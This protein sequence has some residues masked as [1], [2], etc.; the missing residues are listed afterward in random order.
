M[1]RYG[2]AHVL[3]ARVTYAAE[4]PFLSPNYRLHDGDLAVSGVRDLQQLR[5]DAPQAA[6]VGLFEKPRV[7]HELPASALDHVLF[8]HG[9]ASFCALALIPILL[10]SLK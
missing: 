3:R 6:V 2:P 10:S 9:Y 7:Q 8:P 4:L 5:L 1:R